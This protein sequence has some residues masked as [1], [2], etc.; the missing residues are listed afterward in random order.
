MLKKYYDAMKKSVSYLEYFLRP[1]Y[2]VDYGLFDWLSVDIY[3]PCPKFITSSSYF[4]NTCSLLSRISGI[5][6]DN[7]TQKY[8]SEL[9]DK[10]KISFNEKYVNKETG[11]VG[12]SDNG[13][14]TAQCVP[15]YYG[16]IDEKNR[17]SVLE[18]LRKAVE[19]KDGHISTGTYGTHCIL[20]VLSTN[21]MFDL[22]YNMVMKKDFPGWGFMIEKG[23]T[24]LWEMWNAGFEEEW[25]GSLNHNVYGSVTDWIE[26][27]L[28]GIRQ[29][30]GE[31]GWKKILIQPSLDVI[32]ENLE[33]RKKTV[34]GDIVIKIQMT[35]ENKKSI[36]IYVPQ[37]CLA[38][39]KIQE[40]EV[41]VEST[42]Y[43]TI[44][45]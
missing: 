25:Y 1:D 23:A 4:Y 43:K 39:V 37:G 32:N 29:A 24:T 16:L 6:G 8:Y 27:Y 38:A 28:I 34:L 14:Q 17:S 19:E 41:S 26:R 20:E 31:A 12:D 22:A 40:K 44:C 2:T 33:F 10:I 21:G 36:Y 5:L 30:D 7:Q 9:A 45:S 13:K 18:F 42:E 11:Q 15:L 35:D 3:N